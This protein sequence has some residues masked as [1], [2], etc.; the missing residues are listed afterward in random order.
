MKPEHSVSG[1]INGGKIGL[2]VSRKIATTTD[3]HISEWPASAH[4]ADK[5]EWL[6]RH[7]EAKADGTPISRLDAQMHRIIERQ[8]HKIDELLGTKTDESAQR[9]AS[10]IELSRPVNLV[11]CVCGAEFLAES[12]EAGFLAAVGK[13][14]GC[15][16]NSSPKPEASS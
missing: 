16:E 12:F 4:P 15:N 14:P 6:Y 7:F 5:M 2:R 1:R 8:M 3:I 9:M 10:M 11:G 13:C